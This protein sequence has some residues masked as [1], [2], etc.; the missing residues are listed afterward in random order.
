VSYDTKSAPIIT[1]RLPEYRIDRVPDHR[2]LGG[3]VDAE[4]KKY[5]LG[6]TIIARGIGSSEHP[7]KTIDE[8]IEIIHHYGTDRYD[9]ARLGD[10]YENI[11]GK[12]IDLFGFRRKITGRMNLFEDIIYGFYH[13]AISVHGKPTRI[14]IV[15]IYDVSKLRAVV[16]QYE[17]RA[18]KKRNGFVFKDPEQKAKALLGIVKITA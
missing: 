5:F 10:R 15:T 2:V 8:L 13:G 11:Q 6:Q 14:D 3:A 9:A 1:V 7:N 16:H 18:D 4:I 12:H 17:G